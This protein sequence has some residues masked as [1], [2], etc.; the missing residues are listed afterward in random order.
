MNASR[1]AAVVIRIETS[2]VTARGQ[3]RGVLVYMV[4]SCT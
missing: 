1:R 4:C 3:P 2:D